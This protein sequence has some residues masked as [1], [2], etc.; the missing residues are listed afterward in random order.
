[1]KKS[2]D[3]RDG[4]S[5]K[6][7]RFHDFSSQHGVLR[8][9]EFYEIG[10][11]ANKYG[12]CDATVIRLLDAKTRE[13][14]IALQIRY[15]DSKLNETYGF[16]DED[17]IVAIDQA[18]KFMVSRSPQLSRRDIPTELEFTTRGQLAVVAAADPAEGEGV[19]LDLGRAVVVLHSLQDLIDVI[20]RSL[21]RI[22]VIKSVKADAFGLALPGQ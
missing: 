6:G 5:G 22:E 16:L 21:F 12:I 13:S 15:G 3:D 20:E 19:Y 9:R 7:T 18:L 2:R 17:E 4:Q 14:S 1:M 8:A 10:E 11:I